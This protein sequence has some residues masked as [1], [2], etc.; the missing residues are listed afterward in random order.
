MLYLIHRESKTGPHCLSVNETSKRHTTGN[1]KVSN[2]RISTQANQIGI[3]R[4]D[5]VNLQSME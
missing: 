4:Y 2:N 3:F 1:M 5:S